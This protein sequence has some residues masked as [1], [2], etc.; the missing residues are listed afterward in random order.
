MATTLVEYLIDDSGLEWLILP[1]RHTALL[2]GYTLEEAHK[3][4]VENGHLT[5]D[6]LEKA[7]EA[8]AEL[9]IVL[10]APAEPHVVDIIRNL[11]EELTDG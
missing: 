8:V 2:K 10:P 1:K 4:L 11:A 6:P 3:F 9:F 5:P 7:L